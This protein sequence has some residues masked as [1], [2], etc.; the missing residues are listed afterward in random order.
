MRRISYYRQDPNQ[1]MALIYESE[2]SRRWVRQGEE[3]GHLVVERIDRDGLVYRDGNATHVMALA[4]SEVVAQFAQ[5]VSETLP[6]AQSPEMLKTSTPA[7]PA[8]RGMRQI[9]LSRVAAKLGQSLPG[10]ESFG[11]KGVETE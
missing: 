9:P 10:Q 6:R 8:I 5:R 11:D 2:G 1:S 7:P 3:L 4:S